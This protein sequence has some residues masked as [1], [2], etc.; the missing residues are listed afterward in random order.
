[1]S[2][3]VTRVLSLGE[4]R[5]EDLEPH[6][7][8]KVKFETA[9][10]VVTELELC[11]VS[12]SRPIGLKRTPFSVLLRC[13]VAGA[14]GDGLWTIRQEGFEAEAWFVNRVVGHGMEPG[15]AYY[16]AVFS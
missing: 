3:S 12:V 5:A 10:G 4:L 14:P 2:E 7:G 13:G 1:M 11:R 8:G 15:P 6:V 16:E 9:A